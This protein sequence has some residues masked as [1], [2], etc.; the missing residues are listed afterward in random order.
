MIIRPILTTFLFKR[1]GECT[2]FNMGVKGQPFHS[3]G[4]K[5]H[6]PNY[7]KSK[8]ISEEPKIGSVII[9]SKL[10]K[11]KFFTLSD[12]MFLVRLQGKLDIDHSSEWKG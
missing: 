2:F 12:V 10:W 11:A 3:Q 6:S 5:V 8:C 4:Q 1:L 7:L 9:L